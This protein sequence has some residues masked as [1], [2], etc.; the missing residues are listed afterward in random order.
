MKIPKRKR[1]PQKITVVIFPYLYVENGLSVDGLEIKSSQSKF[2]NK[3]SKLHKQSLNQISRFFH[4]DYQTPVRRFS[5]I[6]LPFLKRKRTRKEWDNFLAE[7]AS[8]VTIIRFDKLSHIFHNVHFTDFNFF[9]FEITKKQLKNLDRVNHYPVLINGLR[10]DTF[11][12][13]NNV[14]DKPYWFNNVDST[15]VLTETDQ[16]RIIKDY[17]FPI[18]F[19]L[20]DREQNRYLRA[21]D[22]YNRSFFIPPELDECDAITRMETAFESLLRASG[23]KSAVKA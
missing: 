10:R 20:S 12:I 15:V 11:F 16:D 19:L 4:E 23:E 1:R 3:E 13:R 21:M 7:I 17:Y 2:I 6:I 9:I 8:F 22:W 14:I 5:Y 18:L